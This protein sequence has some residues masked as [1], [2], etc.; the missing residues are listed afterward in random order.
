MEV[1]LERC[2]DML[3]LCACC[4]FICTLTHTHI[5]IVFKITNTNTILII[6]FYFCSYACT[7]LFT[8][9]VYDVLEVAYIGG[10][11]ISCD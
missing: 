6:M 7:R 3:K 10:K 11:T 1:G 9:S 4:L 2:F 5:N 8:P